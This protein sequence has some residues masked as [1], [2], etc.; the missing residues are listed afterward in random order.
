[1][2]SSY[3]T[4]HDFSDR[5]QLLVGVNGLDRDV[6]VEARRTGSF[7]KICE[8]QFFQLFVESFGDC[9]DHRNLSAVGGVEVEKEIVRMFEVREAA[10]PGIVIYAT[11]SG[12]KQKGSA[13]VRGCVVNFLPSLF[14]I[15][16]RSFKRLRDSLA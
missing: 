5:S 2:L 12:E 4:R 9:Y 6:D 8:T 13:V 16:R 15:E 11:E 7:Q 1:M 3:G 14:G 10:G